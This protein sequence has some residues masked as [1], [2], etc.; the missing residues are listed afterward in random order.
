LNYDGIRDYRNS[1]DPDNAWSD[2]AQQTPT[3]LKQIFKI[4]KA[5][6][7]ECLL[8]LHKKMKKPEQILMFLMQPY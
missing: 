5:R 2:A 1:F 4:L 6:K 7:V 3:A 8:S